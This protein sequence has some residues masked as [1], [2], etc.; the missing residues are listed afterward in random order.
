[1]LHMVAFYCWPLPHVAYLALIH[2]D[3][4]KGGGQTSWVEISSC[5]TWR[6]TL[7]MFD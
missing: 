3:E 6:G 1:M 2:T 5:R 7:S 4:S